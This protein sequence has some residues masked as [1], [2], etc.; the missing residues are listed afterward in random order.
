VAKRTHLDPALLPDA[1]MERMR[2]EMYRLRRTVLSLVPQPFRAVIDP[3]Y[4]F[5]REEGRS[6]DQDVVDKVLQ[7]LKPDSQERAACPL[8]GDIAR[9]YGA[10]FSVPN[11]LERHLLGSHNS[12]QCNVMHA[13][14]GLLRVRHRELYPGDYGPYGC[15]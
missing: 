8:C 14:Q 3:P 7:L 5:T 2:A 12:R 9:T 13:A 11:G 10:G 1:R 6:W 15:D 4:E